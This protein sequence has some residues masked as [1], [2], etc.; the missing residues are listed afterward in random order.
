MAVRPR[1]CRPVASSRS[2]RVGRGRVA[3]SA[4]RASSGRGP[5]RSRSRAGRGCRRRRATAVPR[6]V[7]LALPAPSM[8]RTKRPDSGTRSSPLQSTLGAARGDRAQVASDQVDRPGWGAAED[9]RPRPRPSRRCRPVRAGPRRSRA[10][11]RPARAVRRSRRQRRGARALP[12]SAAT[13]P[14]PSAAAA[15]G[16]QARR[17]ATRRRPAAGA[18]ARARAAPANRRDPRERRERARDARLG[19][20]LPGL[21]RGGAAARARATLFGACRHPSPLTARAL[22][23][24]ST[25]GDWPVPRRRSCGSPGACAGS[26]P[27]PAGDPRRSPPCRPLALAL[28][29]VVLLGRLAAG[30][31]VGA[32]GR[33]A[34]PPGP[35]RPAARGRCST[36]FARLPI[37]LGGAASAITPDG[38]VYGIVTLR[39]LDGS[40]RLVFLPEPAVRRHAHLAPRRAARGRLRTCRAHSRSSRSS[41]TRSTWPAST[42][43]RGGCSAEGWPSWPA[44]TPPSRRSS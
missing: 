32:P 34:R 44:S 29:G 28:P 27:L 43:W 13:I 20:Y 16:R 35:A 9:R 23:R 12:V 41:S 39:I 33:S 37:A 22:P 31:L 24:G 3:R 8:K 38:T 14:K 5:G 11:S 10:G 30:A 15:A 18:R 40:E 1:V 26:T 21:V 2:G 4:A 42:A 19:F 25:P 6:S 17:A 36:V 7:A